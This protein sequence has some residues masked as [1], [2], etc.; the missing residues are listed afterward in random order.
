[1]RVSTTP[2]CV[3]L[4]CLKQDRHRDFNPQKLNLSSKTK[5]QTQSMPLKPNNSKMFKSSELKPKLVCLMMTM[6]TASGSVRVLLTRRDPEC[7]SNPSCLKASRH[8]K[9]TLREEDPC[10][11][12]LGGAVLR[13]RHW[14]RHPWSPRWLTKCRR[15]VSWSAWRLVKFLLAQSLTGWSLNR[16]LR[17]SRKTKTT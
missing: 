12:L 16:F 15:T 6:K 3:N 13:Q 1:M 7:K 10:K 2:N 14:R 11:R 9:S 5:P 8:R 17:L 4:N